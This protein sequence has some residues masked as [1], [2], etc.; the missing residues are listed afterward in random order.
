MKPKD[1][2]GRRTIDEISGSSDGGG[3]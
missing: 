3:T 2:N 1:L